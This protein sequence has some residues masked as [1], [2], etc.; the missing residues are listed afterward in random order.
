MNIQYA[1]LL[2]Y[3]KTPPRTVLGGYTISNRAPST[4]S[5]NSP[6]GTIDIISDNQEKIKDFFRKVKKIKLFFDFPC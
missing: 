1:F 2:K 6:F 5:D 3:I 4:S